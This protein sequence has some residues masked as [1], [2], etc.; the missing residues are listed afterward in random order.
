MRV[1]C[2]YL[3]QYHRFPENDA[4]WG[5][6]YTEWTAVKRAVPLYKGHAQP[7]HP[8]ED[9]YYDL[10]KEGVKTLKWQAGL[11]RDYGIYGFCFY[12]YWFCGKQLME[13]PMET[14]LAH[15]EIDLR[16]SICWAN[17]SFT[18]TWYGLGDQVL[19]RQEYGVEKDWQ[20]HFT[21]LLPF[22][23]DKRYMKVGNKPVLHI[24]RTK[25]IKHLDK[26]LA[27]FHKLAKNNGFDGM[28][29]VGGRTA[30]EEETREGLV[31][32]YYTFEPG[33]TLKHDFGR[34]ASIEYQSKVLWRTIW[35]K[36]FPRKK[37]E[38]RISIDAI[39]VR[40]AKREV[41]E[42]VYP[43]LFPKWDNTP[44]RSY[45][46]LVYE[47]DSPEKFLNCLKKLKEK[48]DG[49]K[50]DFV[51]INA[52]NEWGEGAYLE[53]DKENGFAYL[54]AVLHAGED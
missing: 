12:H 46:G 17:E 5:K 2:M 19:M 11:A 30:G 41:E 20:R 53:P 33:Y 9:W 49:R 54:E 47:G 27:C 38:R 10:E 26:M 52:W 48:V 28:F 21:Y 45:K 40:I 25:D 15:P 50:E 32:A 37:L 6:G 39:F 3:P 43:G 42:K 24:Y 35:N 22:F 51:Y 34:L 7:R 44:R 13:K 23:L 36:L 4:W 29:I 8:Y 14:L 31:D 1:I 18:R 16:Y